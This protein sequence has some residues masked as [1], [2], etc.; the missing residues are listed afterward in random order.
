MLRNVAAA[1]SSALRAS[2]LCLTL[3]GSTV[4]RSAMLLC[5]AL[6]SITML[7]TMLRQRRNAGC[8]QESCHYY[9]K[10]FHVVSP[11]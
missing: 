2:T 4:L 3:L 6:P 8:H 10:L 5:A 1:D 9:A 11:P 7:V